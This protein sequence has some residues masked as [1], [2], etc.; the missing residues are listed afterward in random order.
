MA[1]EEKKEQQKFTMMCPCCK[2]P[3]AGD[4]FNGITE[5]DR[6]GFLMSMLG[7]VP[8]EHTYEFAKGHIKITV[9]ALTPDETYMQ[10]PLTTALFKA[11]QDVPGVQ[12][13]IMMITELISVAQMLKSI[14]VSTPITDKH[15]DIPEPTELVK[16]LEYYKPTGD[17]AKDDQFLSG[18]VAELHALILGG[19][20]IPL[21]IVTEAVTRHKMLI[22]KLVTECYDSDFYQGVGQQS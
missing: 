6:E 13:Q 15:V 4:Q 2:Q 5:E 3:V 19:L 7:D 18:K 8:F 14:D 17:F 9:R 20:S 12:G 21:V 11:F 1:E 16:D 22:E 10:V